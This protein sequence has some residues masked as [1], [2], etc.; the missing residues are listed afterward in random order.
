MTTRKVKT[1]AGLSADALRKRWDREDVHL[2]GAVDSTND[3]AREL[4]DGGAP[5]GTIVLAR[6]QKGGRGR[7]G[8]AWHSPPGGL[9]L[10]MVFRP[11]GIENPELLPLL[12]GLGIVQEVERRFEGL[13]PALK[14]PNDLM[15]DDRKVGGILCEAVW[16]EDG[17]RHLVVGTGVNVAPLE[18]GA[19]RGLRG[20]ATSLEAVLER[21]VPLEEVADAV[22]AGLEAYLPRAPARLDA[23]LLALTDRYDWLRDRRVG[24]TPLD[25]GETVAGT[26]VGI[27]PDGALLFRPDRGALRRLTRVSV[28]ADA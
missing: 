14:W 20:R 28:E 25:G 8:R 13:R 16:G 24:V 11:G 3:L 2:Y 26:C 5:A 1:W 21:E 15:A 23:A 6:E 17:I 18:S 12:A 9:Y 27:A 4:A 22:I 10:S 19:P 7:A